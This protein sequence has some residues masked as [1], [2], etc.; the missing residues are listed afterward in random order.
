[1][2]PL[3]AGRNLIGAGQPDPLSRVERSMKWGG[4]VGGVALAAVASLSASLPVRAADMTPVP[5]RVA[6]SG[7]IPAQFLWTGFYL[8]GGIG[9]G[10]GTATTLDPLAP[11]IASPSLKG[12]LVSGITGINYQIS[13]VVVGVEGDFTGSW[14]KGS[15]IDTAGNALQ[16]EV[17]W[18]AS[19]TGRVGVAFDRLLIY[20]KGG[21]G[22]DYDR[23]IVTVP[24]SASAI[25][26]AYHVGWTG[27]GGVEYA[28]TEHWTARLEYDYFKFSTKAFGFQ[29][30]AIPTP[31]GI[32]NGNVGINL[33]ELTLILAYKF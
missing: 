17:F 5:Q 14:A 12:F 24:S 23:N 4:V 32:I 33:N 21:V 6:A 25:G 1:L 8:G 10:W 7:Y 26:T 31:P 22:F 3:N 28:V 13:S 9:Y 27:G 11:V 15:A 16:T 29:G 18:T 30:P 2:P 19:I 20:G